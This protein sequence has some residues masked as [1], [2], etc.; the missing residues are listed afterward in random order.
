MIIGIP[1]ELF[2]GETRIP[3]IPDSV[4]KF[5]DKGAEVLVETGLGTS[6]GIP[7]ND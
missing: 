7:D 5:T 3:V 2:A 4:K 6:I 1:K